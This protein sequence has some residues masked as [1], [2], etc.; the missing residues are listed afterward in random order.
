MGVIAE[1]RNKETTCKSDGCSCVH[2]SEHNEQQLERKTSRFVIW[3]VIYHGLTG[4]IELSIDLAKCRRPVSGPIKAEN[5]SNICQWSRLD[6]F[7]IIP[8]NIKLINA[9]R[10]ERASTGMKHEHIF[11]SLY[12]GP[13][14]SWQVKTANFTALFPVYNFPLLKRM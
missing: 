5:Q 6:L 10:T 12:F 7:S 9:V 4:V 8:E 14:S 13:H 2:H 3:D 1:C 11:N